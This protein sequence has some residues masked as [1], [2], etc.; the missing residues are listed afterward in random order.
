[1][2]SVAVSKNVNVSKRASFVA[3]DNDPNETKHQ[4]LSFAGIVNV[5]VGVERLK[6][7]HGNFHSLEAL[8]ALRQC[9]QTDKKLF[10]K[11]IPKADLMKLELE[12]LEDFASVLGMDLH[13]VYSSH[14]LKQERRTETKKEELN[15]AQSM[16]NENRSQYLKICIHSINFEEEEKEKQEYGGMAEKVAAPHQRRRASLKEIVERN[17]KTMSFKVQDVKVRVSTLFPMGTPREIHTSTES[18]TYPPIWNEWMIFSNDASGLVG[19]DAL[20]IR[21]HSMGRFRKHDVGSMVLSVKKLCEEAMKKKHNRIRKWYPLMTQKANKNGQI[22]DQITGRI[23]M[24]FVIKNRR[25]KKFD[26]ESS[27]EDEEEMG[28]NDD[29]NDDDNNNDDDDDDDNE[30]DANKLVEV[31]LSSQPHH[32]NPNTNTRKRTK[33]SWRLAMLSQA[34]HLPHEAEED[35]SSNE[36]VYSDEEEAEVKDDEQEEKENEEEM[37]DAEEAEEA[38]NKETDTNTPRMKMNLSDLVHMKI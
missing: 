13:E 11:D 12:A 31:L 6:K 15:N 23:D 37:V 20:E 38:E 28:S 3:K 9:Q 7:M 5:A 34:S 29:D 19:V 2:G 8:N 10:L 21:V 26:W 4:P 18:K 25:E 1:V 33:N 14:Y 22:S 35:T 36:D 24:Q 27:S 17:S 16:L 30:N 32:T